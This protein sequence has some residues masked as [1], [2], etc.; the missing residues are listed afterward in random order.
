MNPGATGAGGPKREALIEALASG[1]S[2]AEA[3]Q[4][5]GV[6]KATVSRRMLEPD[7]R[8]AVARA[9]AARQERVLGALSE[10]ALEAVQTL[11]GL[12]SSSNDSVRASACKTALES[13][14]KFN[15]SVLFEERLAA[16]EAQVAAG[17][18]PIA[19]GPRAPQ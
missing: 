15:A 10:V 5:A 16:L 13:L 18:L 12:L 1:L 6:C 19:P 8:A 3:A 17:P 7:F 4:L 9:R 14:L 11:R 2:W